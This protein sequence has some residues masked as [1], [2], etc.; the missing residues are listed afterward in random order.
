MAAPTPEQFRDLNK[1]MVAMFRLG[2]GPLI[3]NRWS[4]YIM[5]LTTVGRKSGLLRR[6]P[7]NYAIIDGDVY[8]TA[9]FG[10]TSHWYRNFQADPA[11]E[12]WIGNL[13]WTG[14]A[15]TVTGDDPQRLK[16]LR[17]VWI[18]SGFAAEAFEGLNPKTCS[19]DELAKVAE[20]VPVVRIRR[21]EKLSGYGGPGDMAW[22]WP[23]AFVLLAVL[24][25]LRPWRRFFA[26]RQ[27]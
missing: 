23:V 25:L 8:C 1:F 22:M 19:D 3:S 2:L 24:W 14:K 11:V 12:V 26:I 13:W 16:I 20:S 9:G 27:P 21:Q 5:V 15:E 6:T 17:Q 18:N 10:E 4:G 7:V